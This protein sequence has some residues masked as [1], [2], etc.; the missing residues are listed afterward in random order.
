MPPIFLA[1]CILSIFTQTLRMPLKFGENSNKTRLKRLRA[2]QN[3]LVAKINDK[4]SVSDN[5]SRYK[6]LKFDDIYEIFC[7]VKFNSFV[8]NDQNSVFSDLASLNSVIHS[9]PTRFRHSNN[10]NIPCILL[11]LCL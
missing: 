7:L 8:V 4:N 5:Y 6:L 9:Y 3:R 1:R 11:F 2:M 10:I